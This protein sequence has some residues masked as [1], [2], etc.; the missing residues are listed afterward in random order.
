MKQFVGTEI[1][2]YSFSAA[3]QQVTLTGLNTLTLEQVLLITNVTTNQVIYQFNNPA[4]GGSISSNVITLDF[5]TTAMNNA[6]RLQI[7][8][9]YLPA[10]QKTASGS[11][12]VVLAS[13]QVRTTKPMGDTSALP[14]RPVPATLFRTTFARVLASGVDSEFFNAIV[15][16]SGMTVSQS[17]GNLVI[18]SGATAN[19]ETILRSTQSF[20][21]EMIVKFQTILSQRIINQNFIVEM[22]DVIGD[23]LAL[24]V[25]SAT[26]ITVTI[27]SN[28]YTSQNIGQ[29]IHVG[30][31][32][33]VAA[34]IP[35][36]YAIASVAG[37]NVTFTVAGWPASGSGTCSLF[38]W[39]YHQIIYNT[40]VATSMTYDAQRKGWNSGATTLAINTTAAPGH[41]GILQAADSVASVLDQLVASSA[42]I[43]TTMRGSRVV[44]MP[45]EVTPLFMQIRVLNGSTAPASTTTWTVGMA[46]VENFASQSVAVVNTKAQALNTPQP[47]Q[48]S[49]TPAV[50]IASGTVTTVST[51]TAVTTV[52]AV[53]SANL[54]IPGTIADVASAALTT[55]TTTAAFTPTFGPSY[56][57]NIPVTV[58]TGTT[59]T[60]DVQVQ[61]SL[62][63]GTNWTAVY[64]FP[65]ITATGFY[66]SPPLR[67]VGN[68]VRYVQT[69][70]GTTPS[71]TRAVNRLQMSNSVDVFRQIID[72][73]I[74][75]TTLNSVTPSLT[76][77]GSRIAQLVI[78]IGAATT[79]P[80]IQLE[81]SD[82]NGLTWYAVGSP[83][84]AVASTTV[85][86]TTANITSQLIRARVS[87]A[88]TTV[89]ANYV[90]IRGIG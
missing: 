30:N 61:E 52:A 47:V 76:T 90:M 72:R 12:S 79:P 55:T 58:V 31:V 7:I 62:D 78:A 33:G 57:V 87:T 26:S 35:G 19:S 34:A 39:N 68:R 85:Q 40:A 8:I 43:Q 50:T 13:D 36:R 28:P 84:A 67:L 22:V 25:N 23:G 81:G 15:T 44:N 20:T 5:N 86:Q 73:T 51:V 83:L 49:N 29:S 41:L 1:G 2:G 18:T 71:F 69:V 11:Q 53:T 21:N 89:T 10:G 27:P 75:L 56:E 24:T 77:H 45:D 46:S 16:G 60:L 37:N 70:A 14:V 66:T 42:T 63:S 38:G 65:R 9:D 6:D 59:P 54:G 80:S 74:V 48:V 3:S 17:G 4:L 64:D 32:T 88:G 82:D